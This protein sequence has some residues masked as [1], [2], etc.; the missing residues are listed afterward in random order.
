MPYAS[1]LPVL[2]LSFIPLT[3]QPK[4][5]KTHRNGNVIQGKKPKGCHHNVG[6]VVYIGLNL[7]TSFFMVI[8]AIVAGVYSGKLDHINYVSQVKADADPWINA[9]E[10]QVQK[11]KD[12]MLF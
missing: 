7:F 3:C 8:V 9:F 4:D 1:C 10:R 12:Q 2:N 5:V 6:L 11:K